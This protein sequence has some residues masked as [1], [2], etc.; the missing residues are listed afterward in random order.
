MDSH[1]RPVRGIARVAGTLC[2]NAVSDAA[3]EIVGLDALEYGSFAESY[4]RIAMTAGV[5]VGTTE[6]NLNLIASRWL[7][8]PRE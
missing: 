5:A 4:F 6:I 2:E 8:L 1:S 7:G 3:M